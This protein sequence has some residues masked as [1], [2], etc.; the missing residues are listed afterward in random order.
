MSDGN[1]WKYKTACAN[2]MHRL[3]IF[4]RYISSSQAVVLQNSPPHLAIM[5]CKTLFYP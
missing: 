3:S 2:Y 1:S 5:F 4:F